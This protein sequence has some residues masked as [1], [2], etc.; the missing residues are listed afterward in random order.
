MVSPLLAIRRVQQASRMDQETILETL[1]KLT[2]DAHVIET[3]EK[4][5]GEENNRPWP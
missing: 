2:P 3:V 4:F 5:L 1:E